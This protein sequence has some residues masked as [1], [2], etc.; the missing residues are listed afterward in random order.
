ML[1]SLP[2]LPALV[3]G[4]A[5]RTD[6]VSAA[7][8][9]LEETGRL[10]D[11]YEVFLGLIG[12]LPEEVRPALAEALR[13]RLAAAD[14]RAQSCRDRLDDVA[15]FCRTVHSASS[16]VEMVEVPAPLFEMLS[17][18]IDDAMRPVLRTISRKAGAGCTVEVVESYFP[19][20]VPTSA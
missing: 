18:Y 3:A 1:V 6:A 12:D 11:G 8:R 7:Q 9:A 15:G 20:P 10:L 16:P 4:R 17:P 19:K 5:L 2:A 13:K 14:R